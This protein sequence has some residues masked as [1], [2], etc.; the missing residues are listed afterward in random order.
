MQNLDTIIDSITR[1]AKGILAADESIATIE[2]RFNAI[3]VKCTYKTRNDYRNLI[4]STK[5][6]NK[7]ISGI[8]LFE[9][10]LYQSIESILIPDYLTQK[11][12]QIGVKV[13]LGLT[14]STNLH[15]EKI[16]MGLDTLKER[17][18]KLKDSNVSFTKWRCIYNISDST[19]SRAIIEYNASVLA[20]YASISQSLGYVPIVEPEVLMDG[21]HSID[22]CARITESVLKEVFNKL[23]MHN[24]DIK[25]IILKPNMILPGANNEKTDPVEVAEKTIKVLERCVPISVP[26]INFLS[27]GQSPIEATNHLKI[28]NSICKDKWNLSYSF[29]RALQEP[30]IL[31]WS[32]DSNNILL[33]QE[34]LIERCKSNYESCI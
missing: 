22:T 27:G 14:E 30:C 25:N 16:T 8:I 1:D 15:H 23:A 28:I 26:S 20:I 10:T 33:A 17:L 21:S 31:Q 11:D 3:G 2:K 19:P 13:D 7:Y 24:V 32:G 5:D 4:V 12:I 9:E 34:R 6:L 18:F 29:G